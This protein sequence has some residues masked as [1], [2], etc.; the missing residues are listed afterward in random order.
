MPELLRKTPPLLLATLIMGS[1]IISC[2]NYPHSRGYNWLFPNWTP[3]GRIV[4]IERYAEF[5]RTCGGVGDQYS[6]SECYLCL[7]NKDGTG[8]TRLTDNIGPGATSTAASDDKLI[9]CIVDGEGYYRMLLFD[10]DG[11]LIK[12]LGQGAYADFSPDGKRIVYQKYSGSTP[13]GIWIMDIETGEER[14]LVSDTNAIFPSWSPDGERVAYSMKGYIYVTDT[15]G[16]LIEG[17]VLPNTEKPDWGPISWNA[18]AVVCLVPLRPIILHMDDMT[19]DTLSFKCGDGPKW[20]PD[21]DWFI[22]Y[23]ENGYF[24]IKRDGSS[25]WYL[26]PEGG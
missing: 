10:Y 3:D 24:V 1:L 26:T 25:K 20:S 15:S 4:F 12:D 13:Q 11:N 8:F 9:A 22:G 6:I 5:G 18:I 17:P 7:I 2:E 19:T 16:A 14:C 23:D 21:G